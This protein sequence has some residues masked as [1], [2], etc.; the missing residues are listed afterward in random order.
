PFWQAILEGVEAELGNEATVRTVD[1]Q[2]DQARMNDMVGD[3]IVAG[4]D[5]IILGP[6]DTTG[7]KPALEAA[8]AANIP[9]VNIDT[10]VV[11]RD[12]VATVVA[13][14]NNKAGA[15]V[16]ESM[17]EKLAEGSKVA[18]LHCPAGQACIDRIDGFKEASA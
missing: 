4:V 7:V 10:P 14:D 17:M 3:L 13:S 18:V 5:V 6:Y 9:V 2:A 11:D 8:A 12:L 1:P 16:A 15:L